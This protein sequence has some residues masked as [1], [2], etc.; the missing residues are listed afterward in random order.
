MIGTSVVLLPLTFLVSVSVWR[1]GMD[2]EMVNLMCQRG[3]ALVPGY[4]VKHYSAGFC[5]CVFGMSRTSRL[6]DLE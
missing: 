5:A 4:F 2:A 6:V 1:L 3:W